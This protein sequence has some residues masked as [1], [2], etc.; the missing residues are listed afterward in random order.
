MR[1]REVV[2]HLHL[3]LAG[4][5]TKF[6]HLVDVV[7]LAQPSPLSILNCLR[8]ALLDPTPWGKEILFKSLES[9]FETIERRTLNAQDNHRHTFSK[10]GPGVVQVR[11]RRQRRQR[12]KA[13][14]LRGTAMMM[15]LM[16]T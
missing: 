4:A 16:M 7:A 9:T 10:K 12:T 2:G 14:C 11:R 15:A 3:T 5:G 6:R 8:L 1:C 13:L